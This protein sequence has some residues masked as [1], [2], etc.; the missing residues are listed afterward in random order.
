MTSVSAREEESFGDHCAQPLHVAIIMDGNGR[1]AKRRHL[2]RIAGHRKGV[3]AVRRVVEVA[4]DLGIGT[5]TLYAFSS[6]NWKRPRTEVDDLMKLLRLYLRSEIADLHAKGVKLAVIGDYRGLGA[7]LASLI[8][9]GIAKTEC[10]TRLTLVLAL[11]YGA[12]DEMVRAVR[13]LAEE[14]RAGRLN[15]EA[16]EAE[17][18][19]LR[20]DTRAWPAPD[21][22]IRTSGEIR[23]SNFMLWQ[24]AYSELLFLDML[25]PDFDAKALADAVGSYAA[26]ERRYGAL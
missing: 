5:L 15:P 26:R 6:E 9:D 14:V 25:W 10:N 17:D 3:E 4:P 2:P 18:I 12:R 24:A 22:I 8:E 13:T 19:D 1:W 7:E 11:N 23:L 20:L 21:L 16:I